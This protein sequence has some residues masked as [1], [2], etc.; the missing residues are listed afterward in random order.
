MPGY[1]IHLAVGKV[2][3]KENNINNIESFEKGIIAPDLV[4][5]KRKSHYGPSSSNPDLNGYLRA[6]KIKNEFDEGYFLHLVTDYLFYHKLIDIDK[7]LDEQDLEYLAKISKEHNTV[8]S[9]GPNLS[10]W[11][12]N[13]RNDFSV[14]EGEIRNRYDIE[15]YIEF[16]PENIKKVMT[17][18]EGELKVFERDSLFR[19]LEDMAKIDLDKLSEELLKNPDA[20]LI[21][22]FEE[23]RSH[24]NQGEFR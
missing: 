13:Q 9:Q 15:N 20:D 21:K 17:S 2:Y 10:E 4:K 14:L 24:S 18:R 11:V 12:K 8:I 6:R 3:S 5:D 7:I 16:L 22:L 19:F 23:C 1:V